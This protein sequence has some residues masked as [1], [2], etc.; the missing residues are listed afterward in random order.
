MQAIEIEFE[1]EKV[2]VCELEIDKEGEIKRERGC[3]CVCVR[4][5]ERYRQ[6][7]CEMEREG[8]YVRWKESERVC[9]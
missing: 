1:Y 6:F 3:V 4:D 5:G 7:L 9:V 8:L 2:S